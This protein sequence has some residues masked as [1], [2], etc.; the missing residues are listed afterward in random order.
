MVIFTRPS[1][2]GLTVPPANAMSGMPL[3]A[4]IGTTA[5]ALAFDGAA[6]L[7][8]AAASAWTV[9]TFGRGWI[10]SFILVSFRLFQA[11]QRSAGLRLMR[12]M[13]LAV[14]I[15]AICARAHEAT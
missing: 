9:V 3:G 14:G 1:H 2:T 7:P 8:A 5:A 11:S 13:R 15:C 6:P 12:P 4:L 10:A